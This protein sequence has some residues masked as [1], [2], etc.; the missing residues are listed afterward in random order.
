VLEAAPGAA[1]ELEGDSTLHRYH[2]KARRLSAAIRIDAA[3]VGQAARSPSVEGLVRDH[4]VT[5]FTLTIPIAELSSGE[6]DLDAN[7]HK[8]LRGD[9]HRELHFEMAAYDVRP[10]RAPGARLTVALRGRLTVAGVARETELT[11]DGF[12]TPDG[13]RFTGSR[14]LLM[15]DFG[16]KPPRLMLGA[17]RTADRVTVRF[18]VALR[19]RPTRP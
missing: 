5:V 19:I 6:R 17:L 3:R 13:L 14:D 15:S 4:A 1:L 11:A 12:P 10:A 8:A 16:I 9:K 2:A 18:D 7:M